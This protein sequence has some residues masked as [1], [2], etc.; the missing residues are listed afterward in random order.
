[1]DRVL[2]QQLL[3]FLGDECFLRQ[4]LQTS[5]ESDQRQFA[6]PNDQRVRL[7]YP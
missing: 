5:Q 2:Q 6:L 3:A 4:T 7:Q 1:M